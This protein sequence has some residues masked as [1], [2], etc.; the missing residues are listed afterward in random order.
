MK[1][2]YPDYHGVQR[3]FETNAPILLVDFRRDMYRRK[4]L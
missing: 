3:T 1:V 4:S 2:Q